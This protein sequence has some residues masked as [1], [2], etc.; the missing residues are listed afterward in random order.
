MTTSRRILEDITAFIFVIDEPVK[1]DII[2]L[3]GSASPEPAEHA[4]ALWREGFAPLVLPSGKFSHRE[5]RFSGPYATEWEFYHD[6]LLQNGVPE[7]AILREDGAV[8][9]VDN[10]FLSRR[11]LDERG[12]TVHTAL[13][14]C[15]A[16][17]AQRCLMTYA[18][19]F[20]GVEIRVC[21][22]ETQG[23]GPVNWHRTADGRFT[24][25]SEVSKCGAYFKDEAA[26][27]SEGE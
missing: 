21:P 27:W 7:G 2:F 15:R 13:L 24:V 12:I 14:C 10:A 16:Y 9:T 23:I 8:H 4:A 17:H 19:A 11:A 5:E 3:P 22:A 1:A 20:P 25:L 26:A 6:V 18:W